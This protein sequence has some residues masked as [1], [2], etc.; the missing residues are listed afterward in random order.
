MAECD[1]MMAHVMDKLKN[2]TDKWKKILK[3]LYL[4]HALIKGGSRRAVNLLKMN[5]EQI[6]KFENYVHV[7]DQT[8]E[9]NKSNINSSGFG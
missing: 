7:K 8:G 9:G 1:E 5:L 2:N 3:T 4:I 6:Q